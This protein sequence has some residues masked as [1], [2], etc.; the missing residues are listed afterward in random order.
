LTFV[1]AD[2]G[3]RLARGHNPAERLAS[4][5]AAR[6]ELPCLQLLERTRGGRQ[7]G[8]SASERRNVRGAF[9]RRIERRARSP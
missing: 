9:A 2:R 7:R 5:L 4:E 3:R 6:W 8:S 1:P